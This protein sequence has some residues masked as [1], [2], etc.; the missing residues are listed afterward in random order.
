MEKELSVS[1]KVIHYLQH[2]DFEGNVGKIKNIIKYACGSAY[3]RDKK[4]TQVNVSI[5]DL[6]RECLVKLKDQ[7]MD[8]LQVATHPCTYLPHTKPQIFQSV[9]LVKLADF[10]FYE[11]QRETKRFIDKTIRRVTI[12]MD[13]F[14]FFALLFQPKSLCSPF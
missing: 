12:L 6:P 13:E 10:L 3:A 11:E 7:V 5:K 4:R 14:T 2:S 9:E 1:R 8:N